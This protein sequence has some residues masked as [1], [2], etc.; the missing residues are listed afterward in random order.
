MKSLQ[1]CS[2]STLFIHFL[3]CDT[4][5]N[6]SRAFCRYQSVLCAQPQFCGAACGSCVWQSHGTTTG[7]TEMTHE[8]RAP[9]THIVGAVPRRAALRHSAPPPRRITVPPV[10]CERRTDRERTDRRTGGGTNKRIDGQTRDGI[11]RFESEMWS[12]S[13]ETNKVEH[14]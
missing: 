10:C 13:G 8:R 4:L 11:A 7:R 1:F 12:Y 9:A 6:P 2:F 3:P 14:C 5:V